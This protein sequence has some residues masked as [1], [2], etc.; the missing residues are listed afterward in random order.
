MMRRRSTGRVESSLAAASMASFRV[1]ISLGMFM[2]PVELPTDR[3]CCTLGSTQKPFLEMLQPP[4]GPLLIGTASSVPEALAMDNTY[5]TRA[6]C[7]PVNPFDQ[8]CEPLA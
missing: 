7:A 4:N 8:L 2:V 3:P 5:G 6:L 1:W